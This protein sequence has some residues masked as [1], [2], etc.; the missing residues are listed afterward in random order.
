M[1]HNTFLQ[2][3][4]F[5]IPAIQTIV[6]LVIR[7][8]DADELL[9]KIIFLINIHITYH[10]FFLICFYIGTCYVGNQSDKALLS[11]IAIPMLIFWTIG[12]YFI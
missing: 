6:S 12:T 3:C 5:G 2:I 10:T 1:V 9:G 4:A 7:L 11:L 8:V